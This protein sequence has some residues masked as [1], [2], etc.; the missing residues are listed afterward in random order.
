MPDRVIPILDEMEESL[1]SGEYEVFRDQAG[2]LVAAYDEQ[3]PEERQFIEKA[4]ASP[5]R[6]RLIG[7]TISLGI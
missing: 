7:S 4:K 2:S 1:E 3:R 5:G 6:M